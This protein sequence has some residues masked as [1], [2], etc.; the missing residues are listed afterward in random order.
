MG[1]VVLPVVDTQVVGLIV[2]VVVASERRRLAPAGFRWDSHASVPPGDLRAGR[3][4]IHL[5]RLPG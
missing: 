2:Y 1:V 5:Q 4:Q 3:A